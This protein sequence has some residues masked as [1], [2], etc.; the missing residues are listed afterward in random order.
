[1]LALV[2][3]SLFI[4]CLADTFFPRMGIAVVKVLEHFG[5]HVDFSD[6]QTCCGQP[7]YNNGFQREA[8]AN[9]LDA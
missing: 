8:R 2:N 9:L 5:C 6:A 3:V 4:T 7:I 1:M